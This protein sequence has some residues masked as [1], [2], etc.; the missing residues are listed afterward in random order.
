[1]EGDFELYVIRQDDND[2]GPLI[3]DSTSEVKPLCTIPEV[4]ES[5]DGS[6]GFC[7]SPTNVQ[8]DPLHQ[9]IATKALLRAIQE[10]SAFDDEDI[11]RVKELV[12]AMEKHMDKAEYMNHVLHRRQRFLEKACSCGAMLTDSDIFRYF[13]NKQVSLHNIVNALSSATQ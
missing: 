8:S 1:M 4:D 5:V 7:L 13:V 3:I 2:D 6:S 12:D 10:D 9:L 11:A